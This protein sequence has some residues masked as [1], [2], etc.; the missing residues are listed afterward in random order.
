VHVAREGDH[1]G[2]LPHHEDAEG[3]DHEHREEAA[4]ALHAFKVPDVRR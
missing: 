4:D 2:R 3:D 1:G